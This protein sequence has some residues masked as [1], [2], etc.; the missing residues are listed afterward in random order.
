MY[1]ESASPC[2]HLVLP[3]KVLTSHCQLIACM[4]RQVQHFIW[5]LQDLQWLCNTQHTTAY[6]ILLYH[7]FVPWSHRP[8]WVMHSFGCRISKSKYT[9]VILDRQSRKW[10]M[11]N[12]VDCFQNHRAKTC[13]H[14]VIYSLWSL[15]VELRI[16][17][18]AIWAPS[19]PQKLFRTVQ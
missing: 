6:I 14:T 16:T 2:M 1:L 10:V 19:A 8:A 7:I 15:K 13:S 18:A 11:M 12:G 5:G 3:A 4:N 17:G 9:M